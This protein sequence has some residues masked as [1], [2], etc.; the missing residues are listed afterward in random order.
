MYRSVPCSSPWIAS[1]REKLV[2]DGYVRRVSLRYEFAARCF[3]R[4]LQRIGRPVANVLPADVARYEAKL[5]RLRDG[6]PLQTDDKRHHAAAIKML[7]RLVLSSDWPPNPAETGDGLVV[8]RMVT[9]YETWMTEERGLRPGTQRHAASEMRTLL[10]WLQSYGRTPATL[11][12]AELDGY[13]AQRVARMRRRSKVQQ[14]SSLRGVLRYFYSTGQV[15]GDM[16]HAVEAPSQYALEDIPST[17]RRDDVERVL[18]AARNDTS[19]MGRRDYAIWML[20]ATYGLRTGEITH[21]LLSDVDWRREEL[22]IRHLKTGAASRLPLL[23]DPAN[24]LF[25]YLKHG[26]PKTTHREMFLQAVAP[27][28]PLRGGL[29]EVMRRRLEAAGVSL[30]GKRGAHVLRHSRAQS[31]LNSGV[32]IKAI[33]DVLGHRSE[34]ATTVYLKLAISD[35]RSIALEIPTV[36]AR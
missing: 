16:S 21:L 34:Q 22:H 32:T 35:L 6:R 29:S 33:G 26:R 24:A 18:S 20:L 17:I 27:Y 3:L 15:P 10:C 30:S 19:P 2:E 5:T 9:A 14:A 4:H 25:D 36:V 11:T 23:R 28:G 12:V 31:L 1:L 13:V 8:Q 7:M